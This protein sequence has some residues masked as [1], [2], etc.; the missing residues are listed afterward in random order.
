MSAL[1]SACL[2]LGSFVGQALVRLLQLELDVDEVVRGPG[3]RVLEGEHVLVPPARLLDPLIER[4]LRAMHDFGHPAVLKTVR[5][6]YDGKGQVTLTPETEAEDAWR[7]MGGE[8][9]ILEG[10]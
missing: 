2:P 4:L 8:S 1:L 7:R 10:A 9:G 3:P 5:L 6:G